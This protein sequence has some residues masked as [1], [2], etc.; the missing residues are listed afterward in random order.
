[1]PELTRQR[2]T[3]LQGHARC[4]TAHQALLRIAT[5]VGAVSTSSAGY[6]ASRVSPIDDDAEAFRA[7]TSSG[8]PYFEIRPLHMGDVFMKEIMPSFPTPDRRYTLVRLTIPMRC[9]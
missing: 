2:S 6:K 4:P 8:N 1:V 9:Q 3:G 5:D 7:M